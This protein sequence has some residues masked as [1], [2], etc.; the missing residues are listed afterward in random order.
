M[1]LVAYAESLTSHGLP[2]TDQWQQNFAGHV[3]LVVELL[4]DF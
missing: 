2:G 3:R 4:D 1:L